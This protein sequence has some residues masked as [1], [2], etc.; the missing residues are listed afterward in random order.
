MEID[1][2][3]NSDGTSN[4]IDNS[5]EIHSSDEVH[6]YDEFD[7]SDNLMDFTISQRIDS[8]LRVLAVLRDLTTLDTTDDSNS[9]E[10][11]LEDERSE[12][13]YRVEITGAHQA[14]H[15]H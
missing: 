5:N 1:I 7:N 6:N 10:R 15:E 9:F 14:I 12:T 13:F 2:S 8:I 11:N 4:K 3:D